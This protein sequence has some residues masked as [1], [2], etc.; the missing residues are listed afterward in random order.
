MPLYII[1]LCTPPWELLG[2]NPVLLLEKKAALQPYDFRKFT[3]LM[4]SMRF[5]KKP[6]EQGTV[7]LL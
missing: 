6:K 4:T 2:T 5:K 1:I 7:T 3:E